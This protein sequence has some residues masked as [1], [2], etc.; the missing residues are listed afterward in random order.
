MLAIGM[1]LLITSRVF[2]AQLPKSRFVKGLVARNW[3]N[4]SVWIF[5][6]EYENENEYI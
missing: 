1:S 5:R 6:L 3:L 4:T 2:V